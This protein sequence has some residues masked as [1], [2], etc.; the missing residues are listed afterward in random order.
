MCSE[1]TTKACEKKDSRVFLA[2]VRK[3]KYVIVL[4][5]LNPSGFVERAMDG[6]HQLNYSIARSNV[7]IYMYAFYLNR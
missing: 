6:A 1:I 4:L 2:S 3:K 7:F 5:C